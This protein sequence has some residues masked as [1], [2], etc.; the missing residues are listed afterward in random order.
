MSY[1]HFFFTS[2]LA[3]DGTQILR[4]I[5]SIW[6]QS[7]TRAAPN[8]SGCSFG[9]ISFCK[10]NS[11]WCSKLF[12]N[13][14]TQCYL[15]S[16]Q[17]HLQIFSW[18]LQLHSFTFSSAP[19]HCTILSGLLQALRHKMTSLPSSSAP[20]SLG[21]VSGLCWQPTYSTPQVTPNSNEVIFPKS[22]PLSTFYNV[23]SAI[24]VFLYCMCSPVPPA[25]FFQSYFRTYSILIDQTVI[26][27]CRTLPKF[28]FILLL[29]CAF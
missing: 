20:A 28:I 15:L 16:S 29:E 6:I 1:S 8:A 3:W 18:F 9:F 10:I 26:A 13:C 25:P 19:L 4:P 14:Q 24:S 12:P 21:F 22:V 11:E 5:V 27:L 17:H 2:T 23:L 7:S